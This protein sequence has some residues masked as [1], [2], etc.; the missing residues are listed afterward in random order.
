MVLA[1]N[2]LITIKINIFFI[3]SFFSLTLY[4]WYSIEL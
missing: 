4:G 3:N 1:L 2:L